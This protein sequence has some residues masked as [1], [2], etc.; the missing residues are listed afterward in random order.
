LPAVCVKARIWYA[1]TS[2]RDINKD[3]VKMKQ[4]FA[5]LAELELDSNSEA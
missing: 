2:K 3:Y 4:T 1:S 5:N